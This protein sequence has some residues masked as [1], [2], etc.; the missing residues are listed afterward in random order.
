MSDGFKLLNTMGPGPETVRGNAGKIDVQEDGARMAYCSG[1][2]V[3]LRDARMLTKCDSYLEHTK[4]VHVAR[5]SPSGGFVASG[6]DA[7]MVRVWSPDHPEKMLKKETPILG[8]ALV[9]L[10]WDFESKRI[11]AGGN[12]GKGFHVKAFMF[13]TGSGLGEMAGHQKPVTCCA[14]RPTKPT[15]C[16]TGGQDFKVGFY[17][18][19]PFKFLKSVADHTNF[20]QAV[21]YS[22]D[23]ALLASVGSDTAINLIDGES[24]DAK[25]TLPGASEHSGSIYG[26]AFSPDSK[27]LLTVGGDKTCKLWDVEKGV[28][29]KTITVGNNTEDMQVAVA[30]SKGGALGAV[31]VSLGGD[32][33]ILDFASG[34]VSTQIKSHTGE[35]NTVACDYTS[36]KKEAY[37]G[38]SNGGITRYVSYVGEHVV[39]HSTSTITK[40]VAR[41]GKVYSTAYDDS[42]KE[43][44]G[45]EYGNSAAIGGQVNQLS[46]TVAKPDWVAFVTEKKAGIVCNGS[47][48][49]SVDLPFPGTGVALSP[50]GSTLVVGEKDLK[51]PQA[52]VFAVSADGSKITKTDKICKEL[53]APPSSMSFSPDGKLL[54]IGDRQKEVSLWNGQTFEP[55][56]RQKWVYHTS[57]ILDL[58]FSPDSKFI[59]S[60]GND[61]MIYVWNV[62]NH[63]KKLK[64]PFAHKTGVTGVDW[65]SPTS[66]ISCGA[67]RCARL[68]EITPPV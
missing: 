38:D 66:L 19:P 41:K 60:A 48:I 44:H 46:L 55:I 17:K 61:S 6:D 15:T 35:P 11:I 18:G 68:W 33:N 47:V 1:K 31:S 2:T 58:S 9:D 63:G 28:V 39:G 36:D 5:F 34:K 8:G 51:T 14:M 21:K 49:G 27:Q 45:L 50:D 57:S 40:V 24:G 20:V 54:A 59:A 43:V 13:D 37:V 23:G 30:W 67:D 25:G 56:V 65:A 16:A 3:V 32:I 26:C 52:H 53:I 62:E 42:V 64:I 7:G 12:G 29:I 22:W 4:K 10:A